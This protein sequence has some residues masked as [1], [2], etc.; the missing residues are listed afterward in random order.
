MKEAK[1]RVNLYFDTN[2]LKNHYG[3]IW[4]FKFNETYYRVRKF[5]VENGYDN[6]RI[7]VPQIVLD[8]LVQQYIEKY[9]S[10]SQSIISKLNNL[11][12]E[13]NQLEWNISIE[14]KYMCSSKKEYSDYI[15]EQMKQFIEEEKEVLNIIDYP[16]NT[17]LSKIISRSVKKKKPFFGGI[18]RGGK[19]CKEKEFSDAGFKDVVFLESIIE[20]IGDKEIDY[21]IFS[22]D[23]FLGEINIEKE[24]S[25]AS[26]KVLDYDEG[27]RI[28]KYLEETYNMEDMSKYLINIKG[29][30][31]KEKIEEALECKV[32]ESS[33]NIEKEED[34][35]EIF[36]N[37]RSKVK[38]GEEEKIII[39]KL[40]EENDYLYVIEESTQDIIYQWN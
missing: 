1:R 29:N 6:L 26:G 5:I 37:N 38:I 33:L 39:V 30:Y 20:D 12:S 4:N 31:F 28:I 23:T 36:I 22:K 24:I 34:D 16:N 11:E 8:E 9:E 15:N 17:S 10:L 35:G 7:I 18:A 40:S 3:S 25:N 32:I 14:K 21:I 19:G 2:I 27:K 13:L